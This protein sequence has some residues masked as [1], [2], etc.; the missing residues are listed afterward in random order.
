MRNE[1]KNKFE[2][3]NYLGHFSVETFLIMSLFFPLT[4]F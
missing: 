3:W 2:T 1:N 4:P